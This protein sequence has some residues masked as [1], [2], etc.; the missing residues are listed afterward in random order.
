MHGKTNEGLRA[1]ISNIEVSNS[2]QPA[3]VGRYAIHFHMNGDSSHQYVKGCS[4]HHSNARMVALHAVSRMRV[5]N[6]VGYKCGGHNIFLEDGVETHNIIDYN[7]IVSAFKVSNMLQTDMTSAGIWITHPTNYVRYNSIA[8][9][10][11]YGMW[12]EVKEHPDGPSAT[13][14]ICP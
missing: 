11:F 3:I 14:D 7:L 6:N 5:I 8:G 10:D 9:S 12:Y 1:R 13:S 4:I 2:G